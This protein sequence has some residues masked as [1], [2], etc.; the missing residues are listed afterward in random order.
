MKPFPILAAALLA[1]AG[2]AQ[3][4]A[5][6]A[7]AY[8]SRPITLVVPY[9]AGGSSDTRARQVA[10]KIAGYL[11]QPVIVDN[12]PGANGNIGTEFVARAAP[13]GHVIGVGNL[14]PMAVNKY[15]YPKLPFNPSE[16][17]PVVL[18]ERGPLVLV[19]NTSS[20]Y[21]S[22]ADL[23]AAGKASPGKLTY[24][25]AGNGGSFHLA[26]EL[27]EDMAGVNMVHVPY[28]G[29]APATNDLLAGVVDMMF[30]MLPA[31]APHLKAANPRMRALALASD[32]RNPVMPDVPTFAELGFRNMEVSNW[33]GIVAPKGTPPAI[34]AKLNEAINRALKEPDLADKIVSQGNEVG[35]GDPQAFGAF[36]EAESQRWGKLIREKNIRPD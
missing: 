34:V 5:P 19:V 9:A 13:D 7:R 26:G 23:I 6:D 4:Q 36:V 10:Q 27:F 2:A 15:L 28:R 32:K 29:G 35:G 8:P 17:V 14:A 16:L 30:D 12:R 24:A 18:L 33:F 31:S 20:P 11:G 22:V 1:L 21:K 25:S 3:A